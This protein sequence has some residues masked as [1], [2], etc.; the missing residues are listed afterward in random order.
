M[1]E[2]LRKKLKDDVWKL[3]NNE[4]IEV[5][6]ENFFIIAVLSVLLEK[7]S[8]SMEEVMCLVKK[9]RR[10]YN[11]ALEHTNRLILEDYGEIIN[12]LK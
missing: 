7:Q 6:D 8:F 12:I 11:N 10:V 4:Q 1:I 2:D 3:I 9:L 5:K